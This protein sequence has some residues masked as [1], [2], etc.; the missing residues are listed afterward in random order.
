MKKI[1]TIS[2]VFTLILGASLLRSQEQ[3][4]PNIIFM[5]ADDVGY[6]DLAIYGQAH[7]PTPHTDRLA[8][9]GVRLT[10]AYSPSPVC[11]PTR[12]SVLTGTDPFRQYITSHVLF[13]AE[14]MV[15]GKDELTVAALL[16]DLG[17]ATGV[18]GKWHLGLGDTLPRDIN[19]PGRGP[20]EIGFD[21]SFIVPDGHNMKPDYYIEDGAIL[22]GLEPPFDSVLVVQERT[23]L[24][25]LQHNPVGDWENRRPDE[26]IGATLADQVDAFIEANADQP[27]F[28]YYPTCSIH[29]P[30]TP[31]PRFVGKSGIGPHGDFVMEFDWAVGRVMQKLEE[32][33]I[34][35]NTLLIVTSD[36]GGYPAGGHRGSLE[37]HPHDPAAS[38]RGSK[39][40]PYEGGYRVPFIAR[41]PGR[42]E[43]GSESDTVLSLVDLM[44]SVAVITETPLPKNAALDSYDFIP[45]LLGGDSPRPYVVTGTRGM[46]ALSIREG[47]WKLIHWPGA[48]RSELYDLANDPME[49]EDLLAR[50]GEKAQHLKALLEAYF[51]RGS[52]RPGAQAVGKPLEAI[53]AEREERNLLSRQVIQNER[54]EM[55]AFNKESSGRLTFDNVV[56]APL[57]KGSLLFSDRDY[58]LLDLPEVLQGAYFLRIPLSGENKSIRATSDGYV[59]ILTPRPQVNSAS[60]EEGLLRQGFDLVDKPAFP[61]WNRNPGNHVSVYQKQVR[62]GETIVLGQWAL[63]IFWP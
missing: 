43:A 31:D 1:I 37:N 39:S 40:S 47:D 58:L 18:V 11:S 5:M 50:E 17:Y 53:L 10:S 22:G 42:I 15:I 20:N 19:S 46:S 56:P 52:S 48:G 34:V 54:P 38:W 28:L 45:V 59:W 25:L 35:E 26:L 32:L 49:R 41:W 4:R 29:F 24:S 8:G 51:V 60:Q 62:M 6:D 16:Q 2:L 12:Y 36:N 63:P 55:T 14:P 33:G 27:F 30:L 9:Q 23:G 21:Y 57:E 13:N 3:K 61:L 7:F 44:A